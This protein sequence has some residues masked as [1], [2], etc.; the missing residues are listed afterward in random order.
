M[1]IFNVRQF[2]AMGNFDSDDTKPIQQAID[3]ASQAVSA[4][5]VPLEPWGKGAIVYIP[6]GRYIVK[7]PLLVERQSGIHIVGAGAHWE[8]ERGVTTDIPVGPRASLFWDGSPGVMMIHMSGS[9]AATIS[10]LAL[11]GDRPP[12]PRICRMC[13]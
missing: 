3:A 7:A 5:G 2:G 6:P 11:Y 9:G 10:D 13:H 4:M 12:P 8:D 1:K